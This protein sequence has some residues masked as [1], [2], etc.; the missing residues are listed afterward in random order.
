MFAI[1]ARNPRQTVAKALE[2]PERLSSH[3]CGRDPRER[4]PSDRACRLY[5]FSEA[6]FQLHENVAGRGINLDELDHAREIVRRIEGE[7]FTRHPELEPRGLVAVATWSVGAL[8][9]KAAGRQGKL[10]GSDRDA[11]AAV[12]WLQNEMHNVYLRWLLTER[13]NAGRRRR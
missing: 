13:T 3:A 8:L 6:I 12:R 5:D 7:L 1:H 4:S 10:I 11:H 9:E 2:I